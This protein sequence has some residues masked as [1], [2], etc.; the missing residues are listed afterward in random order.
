MAL[1]LG[2]VG[3]DTSHCQAFIQLLNQADN[4]FHIPGCKIV[5]AFPGGSEAFSL[6]KNRVAQFTEEV[7][8]MGVEIVDRLEDL[9]GLDG[10]FL[11]SVD[12]NQ[13][14][15]QFKV[16]AKF[17]KPVFIDKP[18]ACSHAEAKAIAKLAKENNVPIMTASAIRYAKG[19][20]GLIEA[21]ETVEACE[22]FGPMAL[23]EDYRDYF[24]Y[25]IHSA[26]VLFSLMG[27][28]CVSVQT[29]NTEKID[30]I[31]GTWNDGRIGTLRGNRVGA[32]NFGCV[33]TTNKTTKAS[34][35]SAEVPYYAMMMKKVVPF[36]QTGISAIDLSESLEIIAFLD[37]AS[38]SR[39]SGGKPVKIAG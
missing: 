33:V 6:S 5:K 19:I 22:A 8:A 9:A 17:G 32:N 21:D 25:G 23:L 38:Q 27:K 14:L 7:R 34:L 26:D 31:V 16:L 11:E 13:H 2:M 10:Y 12:G 29:F 24:W 15:E 4:Q 28:G 35:A 20:D 3:L 39:A 37:A 18:L 30:V 36:F 1:K